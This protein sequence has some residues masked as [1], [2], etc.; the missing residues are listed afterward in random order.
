[1][2]IPVPRKRRECYVGNLLQGAR[3]KIRGAPTLLCCPHIRNLSGALLVPSL[4][5]HVE[6]PWCPLLE[7]SVVCPHLLSKCAQHS[8]TRY[9]YVAESRKRYCGMH[10]SRRCS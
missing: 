3:W 8:Q 10:P 1:M 5:A 7:G 9:Y 6:G 4:Y 2:N